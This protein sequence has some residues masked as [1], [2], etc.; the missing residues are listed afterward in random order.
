M[1]GFLD[2]PDF[3]G[4]TPVKTMGAQSY[5]SGRR[6]ATDRPAGRGGRSQR[7]VNLGKL[8]SEIGL[9]MLA[10]ALGLDDDTLK[11]IIQGRLP[12]ADTRFFPHICSRL[13]SASIPSS[14]LDGLAPITPKVFKKLKELASSAEDRTPL[15][16]NNFKRLAKAFGERLDV[17]ADALEMR[18]SSITEVAD[19]RLKLD[20]ER[21]G[22]LNPR[23]MRAGFPNGWL[24]EAEPDLPQTLIDAITALA[25]EAAEEEAAEEAA[26]AE[27][28]ARHREAAKA[29]A[30][31]TSDTPEL[32]QRSPDQ[33]DLSFGSLTRHLKGTAAPAAVPPT[34]VVDSDKPA[35]EIEMSPAKKKVEGAPAPKA[36]GAKPKTPPSSAA[37]KLPRG[38]RGAGRAIPAK[39]NL[40]G[41]PPPSLS[42]KPGTK[43][44]PALTPPP[45]PTPSP[46]P[47]PTNQRPELMAAVRQSHRRAEGS[48]FTREQSIERA[49]ALNQLLEGARRGAKSALWD[50][51]MGK[52]LP[53]WGNIRRGGI[54]FKDELANQVV[55]FLELPEGW[56]DNPTYPPE[57]IAPW[58]LN[59]D[60]P[61]PTADGAQAPAKKAS[62]TAAKPNDTQQGG[63]DLDTPAA[64]AAPAT[65][66]SSTPAA[67]RQAP[68]PASAAQPD[69]ETFTWTPEAHPEPLAAPGPIAQALSQTILRL[70]QEGKMAE[71]DAMKMLYF[72]M[73]R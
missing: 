36:G 11:A 21:F 4:N 66:P 23:L 39:G 9:D 13:D 40:Q 69:A 64:A 1:S 15:R 32:Q 63:L 19:G 8:E 71:Q 43:T 60:V 35:L 58:V 16:R 49:N 47:Q 24:N 20:E 10:T 5:G 3:Q 30:Q 61:L 52:G 72:M 31:S 62:K 12:D 17:L 41:L 38:A 37:A 18:L 68:R 46:A 73:T 50:V 2:R 45:A 27:E 57:T 59:A 25:K 44:A 55:K 29:A 48:E 33:P 42:G 65:A 28:S 67:P 14:I 54:L 7:A 26:A 53:Y 51:L 70:S 34:T 56:L 22:H 6:G